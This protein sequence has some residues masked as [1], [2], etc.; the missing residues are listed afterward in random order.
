MAVRGRLVNPWTLYATEVRP[1]IW[2]RT[3]ELTDGTDRTLSAHLEGGPP[4]RVPV[5][6]TAAGEAVGALRDQAIAVFLAGDHD[7]LGGVIGRYL[8]ALGF[9]RDPADLRPEMVTQVPPELLDPDSIRSGAPR[10]SATAPGQE[11]SAQ[12]TTHQHLE[13]ETT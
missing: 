7:A 12:E 13:V 2:A 1:E 3:E 4:L 6:H 10:D 8:V 9:L 11:L 5:R